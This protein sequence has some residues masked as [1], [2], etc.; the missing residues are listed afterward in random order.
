MRSK[1]L[2]A[3][4]KTDRDLLHHVIDS[5]HQR[6]SELHRSLIICVK[7]GV[8]EVGGR[9]MSYHQR[10]IAVEYIK[11]I[12]GVTRVVDQIVVDRTI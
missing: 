5:L 6:D 9:V 4:E 10:Q 3:S 8:V 12:V 1:D 11:R 7:C 2:S